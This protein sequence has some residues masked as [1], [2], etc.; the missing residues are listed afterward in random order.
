[1]PTQPLTF[2]N[3]YQ[4]QYYDTNIGPYTSIKLFIKRYGVAAYHKAEVVTNINGTFIYVK[5]ACN[6]SVGV[7]SI[8]NI[9]LEDAGVRL[10]VWIF[11]SPGNKMVFSMKIRDIYTFGTEYYS[12]D[13]FDEGNLASSAVIAKCEVNDLLRCAAIMLLVGVYKVHGWTEQDIDEYIVN[14]LCA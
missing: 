3:T 5:P 13:Y 7:H 11:K 14:E 12:F 10:K 4:L 9:T 6:L 2:D 8:A 1:M